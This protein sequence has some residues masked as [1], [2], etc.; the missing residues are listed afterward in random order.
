MQCTWMAPNL[1]ADAR[2]AT[3]TRSFRFDAEMSKILDEEAERMGVS[4]NALVG[5]IL[6]RYSEFTRYLSK[7]DMIVLNRELLISL[8]EA[9]DE[10]YLYKLGAKLGG[11]VSVDTIMFWKKD[12]TE[13]SV[14]E[15]IEKIICLYGHLGTYDEVSQPDS[16]TI[17]I[18]HRLG[19]KGSKF[20][21]G[22]LRS[23]LKN[24]VGKDAT[25]EVTD[26]SIKFEI[27]SSVNN[28]E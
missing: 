24:T 27:R 5:I 9:K 14:L 15:Y 17:V 2:S 20:F 23:T 16:K 13:E 19:R 21:E 6:K 18:R 7:I 1:T 10:E 28:T 12:V 26:S 3:V 8:L 22:Y 25:F 4:V 11:T